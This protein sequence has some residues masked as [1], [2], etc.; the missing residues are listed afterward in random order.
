MNKICL[1]SCNFGNYRN[2]LKHGID[3][4]QVCKD[5]DYYFFT[6]NPSLRS[7]IWNIIH[8]PLLKGD[9]NMNSFRWTN[10]HVKFVIPDIL[11]HYEIIVWCDN[12]LLARIDNKLIINKRKIMSLFTDT[13]CTLVNIRNPSRTT[14]QQEINTTVKC[15]N[16]NRKNA[17]KFLQQIQHIVYSTPLTDNCLIIRKTDALTNSLFEHV[18]NLLR[19]YGLKRDQNVYNHAIQDINYPTKNIQYIDMKWMWGTSVDV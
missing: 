10:K 9:D 2:E 17:L 13:E 19:T 1:Y 14:P 12:K 8:C 3:N 5:I 15:H 4:I 11:K 6:D 18:F 16:E 7:D